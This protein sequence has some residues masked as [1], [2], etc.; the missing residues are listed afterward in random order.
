MLH[1]IA[2]AKMTILLLEL[3][4]AEYLHIRPMHPHIQNTPGDS[5]LH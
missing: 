5:Q 2:F 3:T 4:E 1:G